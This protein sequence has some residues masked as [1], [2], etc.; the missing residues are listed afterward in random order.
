MREIPIDDID[1]LPGFRIPTGGTFRF[2]CHD[3]LPCF[4]RCC[5]NLNMFL[6]PYD[7]V[8]LRE[9]LGIDSDRFLDE[10]V[11]VIMRPGNHFFDVLLV[12]RE[13][14]ERTCPFVSPGAGCTVY[15][16]RPYSC[17]TFPVEQGTL[18]D[19]ETA[20]VQQVYFL[21][22]PD[23]CRGQHSHTE[24]TVPAWFQNQ[25]AEIYNDMTARFA[26][27][28][29]RFADNPWGGDGPEGRLG[30]MSFMATYNMDRFREFIFQSSFLQRFQ[31]D[32]NTLKKIETTDIHLLKFGF[33]WIRFFVFGDRPEFFAPKTGFKYR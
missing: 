23:F 12:M 15:P 25:Q 1:D 32:D 9:R 13:D 21:R 31:V 3:G 14:D 26:E 33:D 29:Q 16:D 5:R 17:R 11:D 8:R 27:V 6:Y 7:A 4:N 22:P 19:P 10:H 20:E 30:K 18:T 2:R 28:K 24:W